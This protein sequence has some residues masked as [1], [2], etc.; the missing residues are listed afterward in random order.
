MVSE[1]ID[2]NRVAGAGESSDE[3]F[4]ENIIS[5]KIASFGGDLL[6]IVRLIEIF[7]R[8]SIKFIF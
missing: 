8:L 4:D 5:F 1:N 6:N 2:V 3:H 7:P